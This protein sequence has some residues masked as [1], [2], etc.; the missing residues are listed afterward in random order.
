M[1]EKK[2]LTPS[3]RKRRFVIGSYGM[4]A[5]EIAAFLAPFITVALVNYDKYFVQ[6][7]GTKTSIGFIVAMGVMGF[8]IWGIAENKFKNTF[9]LL[10]IKYVLFAF[11]FTMLV[12][13]MND[14]AYIMWF[15]LIGLLASF[16]IDAGRKQLKKKI[17]NFDEAKKISD[18]QDLVE[19][20]KEEKRIKVK[21]KVKKH[22]QEE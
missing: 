18:Q 5:G 16:G 11:S 17:K 3:Q 10:L 21:V 14:I 12:Q 4:L 19:E 2:Q 15:G 8:T 13:L 7:E 22:E 9:A 20:Y 6:Y 1:A